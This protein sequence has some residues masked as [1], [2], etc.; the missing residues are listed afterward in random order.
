MS[1]SGFIDDQWKADLV[2]SLE[3]AVDAVRRQEPRATGEMAESALRQMAQ[4]A[5]SSWHGQVGAGAGPR[6][7]QWEAS[8]HASLDERVAAI[9]ELSPETDE[10]TVIT[11]V[12]QGAQAVLDTWRVSD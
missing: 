8:I 4:S 9:K 3:A 11:L 12:R 2:G 10:Q 6:N 1:S 7:Q 5:I